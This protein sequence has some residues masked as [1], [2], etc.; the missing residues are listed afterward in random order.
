MGVVVDVAVG[1][2]VAVAVGVGVT[3]GIGVA[4]GV[5]VGVTVAVGVVV[6]VVEGDGVG[7]GIPP[8]PVP[9]SRNTWSGAVL[10]NEAQA[11]LRTQTTQRVPK[12]LPGF[13]QAA[14]ELDWTVRLCHNQKPDV[15]M[16]SGDGK[17][18]WL[19]QLTRGSNARSQTHR[20][21]FACPM[22]GRIVRVERNPLLLHGISFVSW[23]SSCSKP[24]C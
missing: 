4:I 7:V 20:L 21:Y 10:P 23:H 17:F 11:V 22:V 1:V 15:I 9:M 14:P 6:G 8:P 13:C 2:T 12:P 19:G 24:R 16:V 3:L 18:N 5:A